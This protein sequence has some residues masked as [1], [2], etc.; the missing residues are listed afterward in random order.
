M[1]LLIKRGIEIYKIIL[2]TVQHYGRKN[3]MQ[4]ST[5]TPRIPTN[6]HTNTH[7]KTY[8][9]KETPSHNDN[10][11]PTHTQSHTERQT[12]IHT[13]K[14]KHTHMH[15][16]KLTHSKT[17]TDIKTQRQS[18][19]YRQT[20]TQTYLHRSQDTKRQRESILIKNSD[21]GQTEVYGLIS[22]ARFP[23]QPSQFLVRYVQTVCG[24]CLQKLRRGLL[25]N[26]DKI[27][28]KSIK[29]GLKPPYV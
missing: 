19:R 1:G 13:D 28:L 17:D 23:R 9:Y 8:I 29:I 25:I 18:H 15:T 14:H 6:R 22:V 24:D 12:H 20:Y 11:T 7:T 4:Y 10:H 16:Q 26:F 5:F 21:L 2:A 27:Y 3:T